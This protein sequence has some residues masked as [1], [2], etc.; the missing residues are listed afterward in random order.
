METGKGTSQNRKQ[1][2]G[3]ER[4]GVGWGREEVG[5]GYKSSKPNPVTDFLLLFSTSSRVRNL[6]QYHYQLGTK[7]STTRA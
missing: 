5:L 3:W 6:P 2:G 7:Y 1:R 4:W